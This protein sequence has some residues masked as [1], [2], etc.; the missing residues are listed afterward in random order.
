[1][2]VPRTWERVEPENLSDPFVAEA[3]A[4]RQGADLEADNAVRADAA[5]CLRCDKPLCRI[6]GCML[7]NRIPEIH[8]LISYRRWE[9]ASRTLHATDN[10]PEFTGRLCGQD[11]LTTCAQGHTSHAVPIRQIECHVVERAFAEGWIQPS[12]S[13]E[14]SG[15]RVAVVGSGPGGLALAQQLARAGHEVVVYE[16]D[17]FPGGSL[18]QSRTGG[19]DPYLIDRR[20]RQMAAEGVTFVTGLVVGQ[21][22]RGGYLRKQCDILCLTVRT[23]DA[24]AADCEAP[25]DAASAESSSSSDGCDLVDQLALELDDRGRVVSKD[26]ATSES[27]VFWVDDLGADLRLVGAAIGHGRRAASVV[28]SRLR[29]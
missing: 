21:D 5:R 11:C 4:D 8:E 13:A 12:A 28:D 29:G 6:E 26:Y 18:R 7:G 27:D 24:A 25:D 14:R 15:K 22:I 23:L 19:L 3:S 1:M 9:E 20:L 10:F 2:N 17:E 16:Q